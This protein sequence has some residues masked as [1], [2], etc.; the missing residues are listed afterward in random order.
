MT[1]RTRVDRV[2]IGVM[3]TRKFADVYASEFTCMAAGKVAGNLDAEIAEVKGSCKV[4]GDVK[5]ALLKVGGAMKVEGNVQAELIRAKG[6]FKVLGSVNA[7]N[8]RITGATKIE[9]SITSK[10]EI[11]VMG[12]LKCKDDVTAGTFTLHGVAD[13]EGTLK[14]GVFKADL[15]GKST[16]RNL[17]SDKIDVRVKDNKSKTELICKKIIGKDIYLE[18]TTVEYLEGDNVVLGPKCLVSEVKAKSLEVH[19]KSKVGKEL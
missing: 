16:I 10:E 18:A 3:E 19:K 1:E 5:A 2:D 8:L 13:V 11:S 14:A 12:V 15:S 6:A 4:D 17:E 7:D 9:K